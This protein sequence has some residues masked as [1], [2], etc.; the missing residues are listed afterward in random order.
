[1]DPYPATVEPDARRPDPNKKRPDLLT[2]PVLQEKEL[3]KQ[4]LEQISHK[5]VLNNIV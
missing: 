5:F 3:V 2:D 1:M 4:K